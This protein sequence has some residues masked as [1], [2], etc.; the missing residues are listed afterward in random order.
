[1]A[2]L[3]NLWMDVKPRWSFRNRMIPIP[4][5]VWCLVLHSTHHISFNHRI[6]HIETSRQRLV[7]GKISYFRFETDLF[8]LFIIIDWLV[9]H[10]QKRTPPHPKWNSSP[11]ILCSTQCARIL[12]RKMFSTHPLRYSLLLVIFGISLIIAQTSSSL[13]ESG[14]SD[15]Q[16]ISR[17][18]IPPAEIMSDSGMCDKSLSQRMI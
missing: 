5:Q 3:K 11:N 18:K 17:P 2:G 9:I 6:H 4:E 12:S 8:S 13:L 10:P 7:E 14:V 15:I 1:M 16:K